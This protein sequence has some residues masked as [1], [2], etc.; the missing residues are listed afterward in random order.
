MALH[1]A[2][3]MELSGVASFGGWLPSGS[4][5]YAAL[6]AAR[7]PQLLFAYGELDDVV[8]LDW[9]ARSGA[10]VE[11]EAR[12]GGCEA[13][14]RV[15]KGVRHELGGASVEVLLEWLDNALASGIAS[16]DRV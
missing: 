10:Q 6:R 2:S 3:R 1:A 4:P 15:Q 12:L 14:C 8:P 7:V 11:A 9:L 16:R 5:T 13:Q